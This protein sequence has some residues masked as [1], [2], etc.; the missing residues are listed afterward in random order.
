WHV[1]IINGL[2]NKNLF[3]HCNSKDDD[4]GLQNISPGSNTTWGFRTDF[5]HSTLFWC[6]LSIDN[7][8]NASSSSSIKVF[9]N[10][11]RLFNKCNWKNCIW[12]AKDDGIY[13]R[14]L[15]VNTEELKYWWG[16]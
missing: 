9:W 11:D 16:D 1:Y 2:S 15:R 10:D 6:Q 12:T 13:L 4:L 7:N 5:T 8:N 3:T 14:D